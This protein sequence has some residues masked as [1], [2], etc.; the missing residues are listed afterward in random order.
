MKTT[1]IEL[2]RVPSQ[3]LEIALRDMKATL[4]SGISI[5][6]GSWGSGD[7]KTHRTEQ[8][9]VCFAG[10]VMLQT[11]NKGE[12][13]LDMFEASGKNHDQ[14]I[15]LDYIRKGNLRAAMTRL[16]IKINLG[17]YEAIVETV[18]NF[19]Q[20]NTKRDAKVF[21]EQIEDLIEFFKG[22]GL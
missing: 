4:D 8:C 2:P 1:E 16:D 3:L 9:S 12:T 13:T 21:F 11:T 10:A 17:K 7:L 5:E 15:F 20:Y 22:H 19:T 18:P 6:M 14:Y